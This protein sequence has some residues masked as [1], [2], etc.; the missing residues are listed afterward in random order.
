M[1]SSS[2]DNYLLADLSGRKLPY[3]IQAGPQP[4]PQAVRGQ[5]NNYD[6]TISD[7]QPVV[8][9]PVDPSG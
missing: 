1:G 2:G 8:A 9:G 6:K 4:C 5:G 3:I 7:A